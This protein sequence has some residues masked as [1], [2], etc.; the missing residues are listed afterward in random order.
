VTDTWPDCQWTTPGTKTVRVTVTN[1][2]DRVSASLS[3]DVQPL[4]M[5]ILGRQWINGTNAVV[6]EIRGTSADSAYQVQYRTNLIASG[7]SN[8]LPGGLTIPGS[9]SSTLWLD[10]GGPGRDVTTATQMFYRVVLP[11]P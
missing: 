11:A 8:A 4:S 3:V 9:N 7:W 2:I 1:A 10:L 6:A 5:Q